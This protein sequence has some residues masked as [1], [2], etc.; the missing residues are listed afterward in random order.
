VRATPPA[1]DTARPRL[2]AGPLTAYHVLLGATVLL[3]AVGLVMVLSASS[4]EA[5]QSSGSPYSYVRRQ[6]VWVGVGGMLMW[7]ASRLPVR[8]FRVLAYPALLL[9]LTLLVLVLLPGVGRNVNGNQ[10]WLD[11]GGPFSIQPSEPAKLAL[12]VWGAD[13]L[14]RKERMGSL[15]RWRHLVVPLV[16]VA[17][18]VV[19]LILA[20]GDLGTAVVLMAVLLALLFVVGAPMRFFVGLGTVLGALVAGLVAME[21]YRVT[22]VRSFL[23]PFA[24][25]EGS[26]WQ[27]AHGL[28]ALSTGGWWG[29]GLGASREKWGTLPEAHTDF[30]FAIIGE[31]LGLVGTLGV[32]LLFAALCYA[33]ARLAGQT[34]DPFVR[35]ATA[36]VVAWLC[37]QTFVNVGAV[38]GVLP[39]TGIPLPLVSYGGSA[40]LPTMTALGMLLAFARREPAARAALAARGRGAATRGWRRLRRGSEHSRAHGRAPGGAPGGG[41]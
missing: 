6:A 28:F 22:R 18:L 23:D 13:L 34:R 26:G 41:R 17:F 38:L 12:V 33:G 11:F 32:L 30:I 24:D 29:V 14:A 25:Y 2:V 9:G 10:N 21:P 5:F 8:V 35:L 27:A 7:A 36:G 40:M 39:I 20:G 1:S 19:G 16:P 15:T 37:V 3:T 31:E 4:V